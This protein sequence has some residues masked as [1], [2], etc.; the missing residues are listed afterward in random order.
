MAHELA[1]GLDQRARALGEQLAVNPERWLA[2]QL[3]VLAP[4]A[5]P[6]P[7]EDYARRAAAAAYR[8]AVGIT[9]PERAISPELH[10]GNP[11]LDAMRRT[12][13]R[14][15]EIRTFR[16]RTR[17]RKLPPLN[18]RRRTQKHLRRST[19]PA[20]GRPA[21]T[22][23]RAR[24]DEAMHRI[25]ADNAARE[26]RGQYMARLEREAHAQPEPAAERQ[27]EALDGIEIEL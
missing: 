14:S 21:W 2:K 27:A 20:A 8:E 13:I 5:S 6:L 7:R 17:I 12:A 4:H 19:S 18:L 25:A 15:L 24:A 23:C 26:A 1:A 10:R 9:D 11:E 22:P 3:G 16:T